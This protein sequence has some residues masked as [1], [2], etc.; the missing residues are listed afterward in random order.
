M[1]DAFIIEELRRRERQR[2]EVDDNRPAIE[3]PLDDSEYCDPND[4]P[5]RDD[6]PKRGVITIDL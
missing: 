3:L 5:E 1:L 2:Q 6:D 4:K